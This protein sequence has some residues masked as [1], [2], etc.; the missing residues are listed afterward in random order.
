MNIG[1]IQNFTIAQCQAQASAQP[2]VGV[3]IRDNNKYTLRYINGN[4]W[5]TQ[6]LRIASGTVLTSTYSNVSS[7]YTIPTTPLEGSTPS[8]TE[9]QT[10][11][12][13]DP[14]IGAWY[15]FC[16]ASAGTMCDASWRL[17]D[18][19]PYDICPRGWRLPTEAEWNSIFGDKSSSQVIAF[20][21]VYGGWYSD[22]SIDSFYLNTYGRWWSSTVGFGADYN[23]F[24]SQLEEVMGIQDLGYYVR[25]IRSS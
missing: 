4:C 8:D 2:V 11:Y 22:G 7:S 15:N 17:P 20:S 13:D 23:Y 9:G 14:T 1:Y 25:C 16:A 6:N 12:S 10:Q 19:A 18:T 3:D 24:S 21:P 5:M